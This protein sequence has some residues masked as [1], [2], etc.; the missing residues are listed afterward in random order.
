MER[1]E[2]YAAVHRKRQEIH[3]LVEQQNRDLEMATYVGMSRAEAHEHE[4]RRKRIAELNAELEALQ[5]A[6]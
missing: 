3:Q 5:D 1:T 6:S 4:H 2:M